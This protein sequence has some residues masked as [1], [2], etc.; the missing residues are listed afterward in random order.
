LYDCALDKIEKIVAE[1]CDVSDSLPEELQLRMLAT[2]NTARGHIGNGV[3]DTTVMVSSLPTVGGNLARGHR[4]RLEQRVRR[5]GG[6]QAELAPKVNK[7]NELM[8]ESFVAD[9]IFYEALI[10]QRIRSNRQRFFQVGHELPLK[11]APQMCPHIPL[12]LPKSV[13]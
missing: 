6:V 11:L 7:I 12:Q 9:F 10:F 13:M 3:R 5:N 4:L 1:G 2:D 8:P